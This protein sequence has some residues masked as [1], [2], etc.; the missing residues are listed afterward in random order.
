M[1]PSIVAHSSDLRRGRV[2]E[3]HGVYLVTAATHRREPFF[4]DWR[5]GRVVVEALRAEEARARTLA[6]VVMPDHLHWL[7]ELGEGPTLEAV[8]GAVKSVSAHRVNRH[9]GRQGR[10]WQAGYH[11]RALRRDEDLVSAARYVVANPL[12]AGLVE[13]LGEY[14]LWDAVW[15]APR[16]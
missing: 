10:L 16:L 14:P 15:L 7:F 5:V 2:S 11:D 12:R 13:R 8:V 1:G 9:L 6:F 4:G 3:A